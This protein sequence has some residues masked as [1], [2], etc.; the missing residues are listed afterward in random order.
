MAYESIN[1]PEWGEDAAVGKT[2]VSSSMIRSCYRE[3]RQ[4]ALRSS[5]RLQIFRGRSLAREARLRGRGE[6]WRLISP[7]GRHCVDHR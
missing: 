3:A 6:R 2:V 7:A 5:G 1:R 4:G